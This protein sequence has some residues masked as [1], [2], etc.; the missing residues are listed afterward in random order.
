MLGAAPSPARRAA[1]GSER[2]GAAT[3]AARARAR[4]GAPAGEGEPANAGDGRDGGQQEPEGQQ[5]GAEDARRL[6]RRQRPTRRAGPA[7]HRAPRR[8]PPTA[9]AR[10]A[11]RSMKSTASPRVASQSMARVS[12]PPVEAKTATAAMRARGDCGSHRAT[13]SRA[14]T[15]AGT[16]TGTWAMTRS[17]SRGSG[18]KWGRRSRASTTT[19]ASS[20][21]AAHSPHSATWALKRGEAEAGVA[22]DQE[23][24][25][26]G[27]QVSVLHGHVALYGAG[28]R[29]VSTRNGARTGAHSRVCSSARRSSCRARWM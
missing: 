23:V 20:S 25:L 15:C 28:R 21:R 9:G 4:I 2:G 1:P 5:R 22:V 3:A 8:S 26:V 10:P 13:E 17:A 7:R 12:A 14:A 27:E 18:A 11:G 24:D 19:R 29:G 16:N 6:E